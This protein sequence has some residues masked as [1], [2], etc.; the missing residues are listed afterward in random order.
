MGGQPELT[1][2]DGVTVAEHHAALGFQP[3]P[4]YVAAAEFLLS[5]RLFLL[6]AIAVSIPTDTAVQLIKD[7]I[8]AIK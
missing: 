7:T 8:A 3:N 5:G 4:A 6:F 1:V 2:I